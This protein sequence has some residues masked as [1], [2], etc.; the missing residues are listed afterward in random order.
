MAPA[1]SDPKNQVS[2]GVRIKHPN[3]KGVYII[4]RGCKRYLQQDEYERLFRDWNGIEPVL[5]VNNFQD[6]ERIPDDAFLISTQE[7]GV[8][9]L[10]RIDGQLVKRAVT[11]KELFDKYH[12]N[13]GA[14][15]KI[16]NP[17][18]VLIPDGDPLT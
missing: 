15:Y 16:P 10:D 13:W 5:L 14:I 7:G 8:Y 6:G 12:F 3:N 18:I 1:P 17:I 9:F 2:N 11:S 4:D